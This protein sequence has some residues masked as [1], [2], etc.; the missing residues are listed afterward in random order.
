M[1]EWGNNTAYHTDFH[2]KSFTLDLQPGVAPKRRTQRQ[3][4]CVGFVSQASFE[5]LCVVLRM[6]RFSVAS[7]T[8]PCQE[9]FAGLR[10][11]SR[12]QSVEVHAA[13]QQTR[14][15]GEAML[16]CGLKLLNEFR[17]LPALYVIDG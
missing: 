17:D 1:S 8:L 5:L 9:H 3:K 11:I 14:I 4:R 6:M 13:R 7:S 16:A 10:K 12:G 2:P 15:K